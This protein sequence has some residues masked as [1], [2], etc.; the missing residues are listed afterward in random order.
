MIRM[1][2][3]QQVSHAPHANAHVKCNENNSKL[4]E[5]TPMFSF[6]SI[7]LDA[8]LPQCIVVPYG[9]KQHAVIWPWPH[10]QVIRTPGI[11]GQYGPCLPAIDSPHLPHLSSLAMCSEAT[12]P[13]HVRTRVSTPAPREVTMVPQCCAGP[14]VGS[15]GPK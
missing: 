15:F 4:P 13:W 9:S 11:T 10:Q 6:A 7:L 12:W 8:R 3:K 5:Q 1:P 14:G 2:M